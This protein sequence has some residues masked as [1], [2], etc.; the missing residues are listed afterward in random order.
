MHLLDAVGLTD[1]VSVLVFTLLGLWVLSL[2]WRSAT[3]ITF[4]VCA[5]AFSAGIVPVNLFT[6]RTHLDPPISAAA[7]VVAKRAVSI[8]RDGDPV[9]CPIP[10]LPCD[11]APRG[12]PILPDDTRYSLVIGD[13]VALGGDGYDRLPDLGASG[14]LEADVLIEH[15]ERLGTVEPR[16]D[17]RVWHVARL[18]GVP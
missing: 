10:T 2:R 14:A 16:V 13:Y 1:S 18:Q 5:I 11:A 12:A 8:T 17:G 4:A 3:N 9:P 6:A 15:L 7:D